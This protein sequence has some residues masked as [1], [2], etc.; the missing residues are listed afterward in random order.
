MCAKEMSFLSSRKL[1]RLRDYDYSSSGAYFVTIVTDK[2]QPLFS[3]VID[4]TIHLRPPGSIVRDEWLS[5]PS[6]RPYVLVDEN[7]LVIMPDHIHAVLWLVDLDGPQINP[8]IRNLEGVRR[9]GYA[10]RS[11]ASV[12]ATFKSRV[13]NQVRLLTR[14]P[15]QRIWQWNYY[16]TIIRDDA[17]LSRVHQYIKNNPF[18]WNG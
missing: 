17:H 16:E 3:D 18:R 12:V 4:H 5:I 8:L 1:I 15:H 7:Y 13:T 14:D 6:N 2:R 10:P 9:G 11:L